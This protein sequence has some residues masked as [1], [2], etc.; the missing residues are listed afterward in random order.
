MAAPMN[1]NASRSIYEVAREAGV[2]SSTVSRVLGGRADLVAAAT[3]ERV[4]AAAKALGY[5]PN[6]M[7]RGLATGRSNIVG[8]L[9]HDIR[10]RQLAQVL[11]G[12][13]QAAR[14]LGLLTMLCNTDYDAARA[15]EY[16]AMLDDHQVA[17]VVLT[18]QDYAGKGDGSRFKEQIERI[19]ERG[20]VAVGVGESTSLPLRVSLNN[21][22]L[23]QQLADHLLDLGHRRFAFIRVEPSLRALD[24]RERGFRDAVA[25]RGLPAES[26]VTRSATRSL[27]GGAAAAMALLDDAVDFTAVVGATDEIAAGCHLGLTRHAIRVPQDVSIAGWGDSEMSDLLGH[28]LTTVETPMFQLG[29]GAIHLLVKALDGSPRRRHVVVDAQ[30]MAGESTGP[31]PTRQAKRR[32]GARAPAQINGR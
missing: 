16:L 19:A 7:A 31:A 29:V 5:R 25:A 28:R 9:V 18:G 8:V 20:I 6:R 27:A 13:D 32:D 12:I 22:R 11:R 10:N 14:Q 21:R 26:V 30:L 23:G 4:V 1:K 24:N 17:G 15:T 2:S 3:R